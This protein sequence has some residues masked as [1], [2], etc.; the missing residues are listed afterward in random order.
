MKPYSIDLRRRVVDSVDIDAM[1]VDEAAAVFSVSPAFIN[2]MRK[3]LRDTGSLAPLAHGGG[4]Q[5]SLDEEKLGLLKAEVESSPD[6]T[7][8]ELA[9][10]LGKQ[11]QTIVSVPTVCRALQKLDLSRKK[12]AE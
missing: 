8:A 6:A 9:H 11:A 5:P 3:Q 4:K 7:L 12:R 2:K 1:T 10:Y